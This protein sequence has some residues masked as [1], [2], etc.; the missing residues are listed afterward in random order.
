MHKSMVAVLAPAVGLVV[1]LV[2]VAVR[3]LA[4]AAVDCY[5]LLLCYLVV[6][7]DPLL[8]VVWAAQYPFGE[9]VPQ[10]LELA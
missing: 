1:V 6:R 10:Y 7:F 8:G 9:L 3:L 2:W 5:L 4:V